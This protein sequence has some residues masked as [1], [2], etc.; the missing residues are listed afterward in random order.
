MFEVDAAEA[1]DIDTEIDFKF[2]EVMIQHLGM[3]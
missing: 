2:A 3:A 1:I